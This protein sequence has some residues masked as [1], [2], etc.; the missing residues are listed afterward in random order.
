[1]CERSVKDKLEAL[2]FVP[3]YFETQK[4]CDKAVKGDLYLLLF[5]PDWFVTQKQLKIWMSI[6]TMMSLLSGIIGI[7]NGRPRKYKL[8]K[9]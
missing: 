5:V 7:K 6:A 8:K 4:I 1:M 9:N 3:D 2:E